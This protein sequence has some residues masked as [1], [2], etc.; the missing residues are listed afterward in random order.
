MHGGREEAR[1]R[2][3][4]RLLAVVS[5]LHTFSSAT[6]TPVASRFVSVLVASLRSCGPRFRLRADSLFRALTM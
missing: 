4:R 1:W 6:G 3:R 2:R 5:L